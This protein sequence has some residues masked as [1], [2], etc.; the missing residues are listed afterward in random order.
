MEPT[1]SS[2]TLIGP[3]TY[4]GILSNAESFR[5]AKAARAVPAVLVERADPPAIAH[6]RDQVRL[7]NDLEDDDA[8]NFVYELLKQRPVFDAVANHGLNDDSA[9]HGLHNAVDEVLIQ[10]NFLTPSEV[11]N[12]LTEYDRIV[13][14]EPDAVVEARAQ[15]WEIETQISRLKVL[16]TEATLR[17]DRAKAGAE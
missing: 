8:L 13:G 14:N 4:S 7:F 9:A 11:R 17:L 12:A 2:E 10:A 1:Y 6:A 3:G 15:V 5:L 16:L